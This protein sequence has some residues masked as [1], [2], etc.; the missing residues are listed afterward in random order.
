MQEE[1]VEEIEV[2]LTVR[3]VL[4]WSSAFM[5]G[6]IIGGALGI[7][8]A[9]RTGREVRE[10]IKERMKEKAEQIKERLKEAAQRAKQKFAE[11]KEKAEPKEEK[12]EDEEAEAAE[13]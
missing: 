1:K 10:Q 3:E 6:V 12:R 13:I 8:L 9:P 2:R 4:L 11:V 5:V 7:L